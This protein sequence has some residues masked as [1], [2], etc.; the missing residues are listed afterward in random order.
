MPTFQLE[1]LVE[2]QDITPDTLYE[3]QLIDAMTTHSVTMCYNYLWS[4]LLEVTLHR[5]ICELSQ[6]VCNKIQASH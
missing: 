3:L 4:F 2:T 5:W 6:N 1:H